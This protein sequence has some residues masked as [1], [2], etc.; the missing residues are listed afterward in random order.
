MLLI[1]YHQSTWWYFISNMKYVQYVIQLFSHSLGCP[2]NT[3]INLIGHAE[4]KIDNHSQH[5]LTSKSEQDNQKSHFMAYEDMLWGMKHVNSSHIGTDRHQ[6]PKANIMKGRLTVW[7]PMCGCVVDLGWSSALINPDS[8]VH[9]ANMWPTWV[10]S[11]P[12]EPHVSPMNLA[13]R[14]VLLHMKSPSAV[15]L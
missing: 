9:G 11:A 14:E 13:I 8:N 12:D 5:M 3:A 7:W 4:M 6:V 1:R 15:P 10:L 2:L